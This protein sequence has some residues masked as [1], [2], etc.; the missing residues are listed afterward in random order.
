MLDICIFMGFL[1]TF[2]VKWKCCNMLLMWVGFFGILLFF[3][4]ETEVVKPQKCLI[5][6]PTKIEN[7]SKIG[8]NIFSYDRHWG[9]KIWIFFWQ[10]LHPHSKKFKHEKDISPTLKE[11]FIFCN[12][13][14]IL[15][16]FLKFCEITSK[17]NP[18]IAIHFRFTVGFLFLLLLFVGA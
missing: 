7:I 16:C 12:I 10:C 15:C 11:D 2:L 1:T 4:F 8:V 18:T 17:Y 14:K 5:L 13:F 9:R 3:S 6:D